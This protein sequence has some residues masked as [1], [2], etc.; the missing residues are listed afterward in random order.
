[1]NVRIDPF[2]S[3]HTLDVHN[4]LSQGT[5]KGCLA[6]QLSRRALQTVL[7]IIWIVDGILQ[8]KPQMF[9]KNFVEQVILPSAQSQPGWI[10]HSMIWA[11]H[12][13]SAHIGVYNAIFVA[14]QLLIGI[15][16]TF[17][18]VTKT[19]LIASF[20]WT[21]IVWWF[22][23]GFGQLLTGQSL[24]LTGAPG[25]VLI[26]GLVGWA[27]W[28]IEEH[29]RFHHHSAFSH[30]VSPTGRNVARLSLGLS[31]VLGAAL[32]LQPAYRSSTGMDSAFSAAWIGNLIGSHG[33][34]ASI[35]LFVIQLSIGIGVLTNRR[36]GWFVWAAIVVSFVFWWI[37][38]DFGQ[39]FTP[40]GTDP[41]VGPL[42][43]LLAL[44]AY[45]EL[46]TSKRANEIGRGR[47][48]R[49]PYAPTITS[50]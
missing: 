17:N 12:I 34:L 44:C 31:F 50:R 18:I 33:L 4:L 22:G 24:M 46:L 29:F 23:E 47:S 49:R 21:A 45:P 19:T 5:R 37:G 41:N 3:G 32:Q 48:S 27:V 39:M 14:I 35:V 26:Y 20:V 42:F 15:G 16:L 9:T 38:Q 43:I 40:L 36:I 10:R 8:L 7:G 2:M 28:P 1:M 11:G 30:F 13:A 25:G 6:V